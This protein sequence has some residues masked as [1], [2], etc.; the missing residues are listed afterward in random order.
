MLGLLYVAAV[1][2]ALVALKTSLWAALIVAIVAAVFLG[3]VWATTPRPAARH[4]SVEAAPT[5]ETC[6][7]NRP[8]KQPSRA[9]NDYRAL[10]S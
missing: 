8:S 10:T 6:P 9:S 3:F 2:V 4:L 1:T 5:P 7:S